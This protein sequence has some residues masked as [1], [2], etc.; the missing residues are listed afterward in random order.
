ITTGA[1]W[2]RYWFMIPTVVLAGLFEIIG[3]AGR[4]RS[5][6][7]PFLAL[8]FRMHFFV[9]GRLA[10]SLGREYSRLR[11]TLYTWLFVFADGT[12][13]TLQGVGGGLASSAAFRSKMFDLGSNLMLAGIAF[14]AVIMTVF[15]ALVA[16]YVVRYI[17]DKPVGSSRSKILNCTSTLTPTSPNRAPLDKH[18]KVLLSVLILINILLFIRAVYRLIELGGGWG[19]KVMRTEWLFNVFDGAIVTLTMYIWNFAHPMWL[20]RSNELKRM[21]SPTTAS[22]EEQSRTLWVLR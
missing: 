5:S 4:L 2:S 9:F 3:W 19:S 16:E 8:P 10:L 13:L 15:V 14:Q 17:Y 6:S 22:I 20:L 18:R 11:P 21:S 7:N 1:I 12:A